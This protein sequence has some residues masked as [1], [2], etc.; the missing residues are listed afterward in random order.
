MRWKPGT[1]RRNV[2]RGSGSVLALLLWIASGSAAVGDDSPQSI[3]AP[4]FGAPARTSAASPVAGYAEIELPGSSAQ[5]SYEFDPPGQLEWDGDWDSSSAFSP[6]TGSSAF[7]ELIGLPEGAIYPTYLGNPHEPRMATYGIYEQHDG[8]LWENSLGGRFGLFRY[9][10]RDVPE[11][12]QI[13]FVGGVKLRIDPEEKQDVRSADFR[14]DIPIS[15]GAGPHRWK[16]GYSHTSSHTGDEYLLKMPVPARVN[17]IR[18]SIVLGY[19]WFPIDS[20]RLYGQAE[21]A[22]YHS[23]AEPWLFQFGLDIAPAAPTGFSG[24]PF[25]TLS[26][27]L[28]QELD[29]GGSFTAKTGWAFRGDHQSSGLLRLGLFYYNGKSPQFSFLNRHEQS[30]GGGMWYDF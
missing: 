12:I 29:F 24:V 17:Y 7:Y 1:E 8:V 13:D 21:Y 9:G 6:A 20:V 14:A 16:F 15:W 11:G 19:S 23:V 2:P 18:D 28:Q 10:R 3:A 27:Q 22:V 30:I 4:R 5:R 26:G 25:L